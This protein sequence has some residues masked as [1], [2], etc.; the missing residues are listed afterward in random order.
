MV[1]EDARLSKHQY[2]ELNALFRKERADLQ[3]RVQELIKETDKGRGEREKQLVKYR[4]KAG[5]YK[6]KLRLALQNV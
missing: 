2:D 4:E 3:Q 6:S 1:E 5:T